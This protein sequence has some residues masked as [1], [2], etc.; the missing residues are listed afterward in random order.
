M[1]KNITIYLFQIGKK[2][3]L[4]YFV[5]K[6]QSMV[7]IAEYNG[8]ILDENNAKQT[9]SIKWTYARRIKKKKLLLGVMNIS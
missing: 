7:G 6:E 9:A 8:M 4:V 5:Q 1:N 3:N 2:I